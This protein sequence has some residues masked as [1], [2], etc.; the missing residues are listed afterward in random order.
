MAGQKVAEFCT[1]THIYSPELTVNTEP[2]K[3]SAGP[4]TATILIR[5]QPH[6]TYLDLCVKI[7]FYKPIYMQN[8]THVCLVSIGDCHLLVEK[9]INVD[10]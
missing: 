9:Q 3:L 6:R 1:N 2:T 10:R 8:A 4:P 7:K 5:Y